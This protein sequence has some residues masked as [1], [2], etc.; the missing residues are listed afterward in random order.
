MP[1]SSFSWPYCTAGI[2]DS[3][4][5]RIPGIPL[6]PKEL[7]VLILSQLQLQHH[8]CLW[9]IGAGTGTITV[10]AGLLAAQGQVIAVE[11]D[12][13]VVDL[14]GRNCEKF[15]AKN[16]KVVQGT[17]PGCLEAL[18]PQPDRICLEGGE[19]LQQILVNSWHYLKPG[20][21]LVGISSSLEGLYALSSGLAE[22]R[23][24]HV[25]VIQSAVN[26][27]Q[28]RGRGQTFIALDP[29]FVVSGEKAD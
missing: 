2:P 6:S 22:V 13:D 23:A 17:A 4:F 26:R 25:E 8:S 11:R 9:D 27:L 15:G 21:R 3:A 12:G 16:V 18:D 20:G 28:Q 29:V 5:E 1:P 7:R 14:I 19:P 10:E 24:R